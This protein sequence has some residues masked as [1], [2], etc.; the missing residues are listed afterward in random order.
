MNRSEEKKPKLSL[1]WW[2][3]VIGVALAVVVLAG[4]PALPW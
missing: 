2:T 4:L 3:V 1:D